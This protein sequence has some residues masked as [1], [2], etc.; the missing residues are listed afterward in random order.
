MTVNNFVDIV[1]L[2]RFVN[3]YDLREVIMQGTKVRTMSV[4]FQPDMF[5][6]INNFCEER[7]CTRSWFINK[8]AELYLS[9]YLED[10]KDYESAVKAWKE[11]ETSGSKGY[12]AEEARKQLG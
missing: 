1:K 8:A 7:G 12:T 4:S 9:E 5:S 6:R 2:V 3:D 11:F 10:K